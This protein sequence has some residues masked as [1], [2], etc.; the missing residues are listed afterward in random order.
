MS[1]ITISQLPPIGTA[2]TPSSIIPIV[3]T[4]GVVSTDQTSLGNLG[5]YILTQAGNSLQPAYLSNFAYSVTNAAQP[6]I[7]SVGTLTG[8]AVSGISNLGSVIN[9]KIAG[10]LSSQVLSTDGTGNLSWVTQTGGGNGST[11]NVTFSNTTI[12]TAQTLE[13]ITIQTYDSSNSI[14]YAWNFDSAGNLTM[15]NQSTGLIKWAPY[16]A[17]SYVNAYMEFGEGLSISSYGLVNLTASDNTITVVDGIVFQGAG[18]TNDSYFDQPTTGGSGIGLTL[19][20]TVNLTEVVSASVANPGDGYLDGDIVTIPG[21]SPS[22]TVALYVYTPSSN[23]HFSADGNLTLP[24]DTFAVKYANGQPVVL[25]SANIGNITFNAAT[26]STDL[27]NTNIQ[28]VG[29]GTGNVQVASGTSAWTFGNDGNLTIPGTSGAFVM[30]N[31]GAVTYSTNSPFS[32]GSGSLNF[33]DDG[34]LHYLNVPNATRFAPGTDD[35]TIEWYQYVTN[36]AHGFQRPFSLGALSQGSGILLTGLTEGGPTV[37]AIQVNGGYHPFNGY[38]DTLNSWQHIAVVRNA[39]DITIY[40]NGVAFATHNIPNDITYDPALYVSIG[41]PTGGFE[42]NGTQFVGQITNM[43]YVVGTAVYTSNFTPSTTPLTAISGTQLLLLAASPDTINVALAPSVSQD[44]AIQ[45]GGNINVVS[46]GNDW[47]FGTDGNLTLPGGILGIPQTAIIINQTGGA[48]LW[49]QGGTATPSLNYSDFS[50]VVVGDNIYVTTG[51]G[52]NQWTFGTD[53]SLQVPSNANAFTPGLGTIASANGYPT[54]LAYGSGGG[55]GSHGG[56]ELDWMNADDPANNFSNNTVLRNTMYLTGDGFYIGMNENRVVGNTIASWLFTPSGNLTLPDIANPSINYANGD[57]YGGGG[58]ANTGNVTFSGTTM[59]GPTGSADNYSVY[60]QPSGDFI[61]TLQIQPTFDNDI[62]LFEKSANAITLGVPGA[63]QI[64]IG[65]PNSPNANITV[66]SAGNTWT[67]GTD[68]NLTLPGVLLAQAS[69]NGS[70]VFSNN[71]VDNNGSLKVDAGLNMTIN[72]NSNFYVKQNSSD[73]LAIT[74]TN[75]DLMAASNVNIHA[76]KAGSE[77]VWTF[78]SS[79]N[80]TLP[81]TDSSRGGKIYFEPGGASDAINFNLNINSFNKTYRFATDGMTLPGG[82]ILNSAYSNGNSNISIPVASGDVTI[83]TQN[84]NITVNA[85]LNASYGLVDGTYINQPTTALT[86]TGVGMTVDYTVLVFDGGI[87]SVSINNPGT[88]YADGDQITIPVGIPISGAIFSINVGAPSIETWTFS[89]TGNLTIPGYI[90]LPLVA[91]L[92]SGGVGVTNSA[93]FGTDVTVN[94]SNVINGSQIYMG[95]GTA[96]S[97]AIVNSTGNSLMYIGVENPGFAGTVAVDPGVTS[98]YAIQVGSNGQIEIGAVVG[99]I[100]TTEYVAGMGVLNATGNINGIFANVNVAVI[101]AGDQGWTFN[102]NGNLTIPGGGAVWTLG[103]STSGLTANFADPY[104]VNLGLDYASNTA[105]LA[106]ANSVYIQAN[107]GANTNQ[108]AFSTDGSLTLPNGAVIKDTSGNSVAVGAGAGANQGNQSVAIGENAGANQGSTA[109]AI[110]QNAGGGVTYQNDDAVAIG[111]SAGEDGQG[112]QAIAI[113]LYTG[114]T[115]QGLNSI[116]RGAYAGV[117]SQGNNSIIL[118]ATGV[119]LDQT[120][121]NT[122]TVAPVRNDV[123]NISEVMFYN[124]TSKEVTYGNSISIAGN[125]NAGNIITGTGT[126]GNIT[127]ANVISANTFQSTVVAFNQL[128]PATTTGLRAFINNG[129]LAAVGNFGVQVGDGGANYVP[130][131]SDGANWC[132]G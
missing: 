56:P 68:G 53:G 122:F 61:N 15:P 10:G 99:A 123:A 40:Q 25:S 50:N 112:T 30:N 130:V 26:I 54:L 37:M 105:T 48:G 24:T 111:H 3:Q 57:P 35:F 22:A 110:G 11:G 94:G 85:I 41:N 79:G 19:N 5:N 89:E 34:N 9:I 87:D 78:D 120:T 125:I 72:A 39:G 13:N 29:N 65:G 80:L 8:L 114:Q 7:T 90:N 129:N 91:K 62:H 124:T 100:T 116:A 103:T 44:T 96:E 75:T 108:W 21:G 46:N 119:A 95:A 67:F 107:I 106:G 18:Y 102:A 52:S 63:S 4:S 55:F 51:S 32:D 69:D 16:G 83:N 64:S 1:T 28:I 47:I 43:R 58:S 93:E 118:N 77:S 38:A 49:T 82:A 42:S 31:I 117:T 97:R 66:H 127:G 2:F 20:Y 71:G 76:N 109:V 113:G 84:P 131:F 104:K 126:T 115:A 60:I 6:S 132:I 12:S 27:T 70:I 23:W 88:G 14:S 45:S 74:D 81:S 33:A 98:A 36:D 73:R 128:P 59:S 121:A 92:N 17:P 86:G 101:G